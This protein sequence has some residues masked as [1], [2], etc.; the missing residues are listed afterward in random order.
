[1]ARAY[2]TRISAMILLGPLSS[3]EDSDVSKADGMSKRRRR[4][5]DG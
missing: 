1:M 5:M 4:A 2:A 3:D